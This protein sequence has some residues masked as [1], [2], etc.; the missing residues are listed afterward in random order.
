MQDADRLITDVTADKIRMQR[1]PMPENMKILKMEHGPDYLHVEIGGVFNLSIAKEITRAVMSERV[2]R[3]Y[4]SV[5]VDARKVEGEI[6][7]VE[8]YEYGKYFA[9]FRDPGVR[10]VLIA[11]E[12][13]ILPD[14]FFENV[15]SN[16][17]GNILVTA[18]INQAMR[19]LG[20]SGKSD[21]TAR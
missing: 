2:D 6:S 18:D 5:L 11:N 15:V 1:S 17:G 7:I 21:D 20:A 8:R 19:W 10:T 9:S 4:T 13:I 12:R 16:I 3:G 14:K